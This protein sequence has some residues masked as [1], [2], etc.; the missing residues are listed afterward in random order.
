MGWV[1]P[2]PRVRPRPYDIPA[3]LADVLGVYQESLTEAKNGVK[4]LCTSPFGE[5]P[6]LSA[7]IT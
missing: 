5:V 1:L 7:S 6:V 4:T 3:V 2:P